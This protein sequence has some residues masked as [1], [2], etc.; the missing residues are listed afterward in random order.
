MY[1][2]LYV[3]YNEKSFPTKTTDNLLV[4]YATL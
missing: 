4:V 1:Y 3:I 2:I